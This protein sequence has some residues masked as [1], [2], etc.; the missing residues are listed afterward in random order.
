MRERAAREAGDVPRTRA[1]LGADL[2]ARGVPEG[3][4]L[5]VHSSLSSL[6]W[7]CGGA[8]AV[9]QALLDALGASS[10]LAVPTHTSS[11][12]D[13]AGW[14][15]PPIPPHWWPTVREQMPAFDPRV[16]PSNGVGAV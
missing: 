2:R 11:N 15:N 9:V 13:P 8:L 1:A 3:G 10:T 4:V 14:S 7:V 12:S 16:S 6:G 5:L